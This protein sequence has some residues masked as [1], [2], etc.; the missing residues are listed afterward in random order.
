MTEITVYVGKMD[1]GP[2]K[3]EHEAGRRL[4]AAGLMDRFGVTLRKEDLAVAEK[5]KP[6]LKGREDLH[7]NIS[8][9]GNSVLCALGECPLGVDIERHKDLHFL[10]TGR[11]FPS[12]EEWKQWE[13]SEDPRKYFFDRWVIREAYLKWKG[14]GIDRDLR[15]LSFDGQGRLFHVADGYSAAVWTEESFFLRLRFLF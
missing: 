8:H 1:K 14:T 11:R 12:E 5:G 13:K 3:Q 7:F 10:R 2:K 6:Y 4:L 9:S 15:S